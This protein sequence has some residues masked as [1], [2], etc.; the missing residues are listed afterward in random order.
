M[1]TK[2]NQK[3]VALWL[4]EYELHLFVGK[5]DE[6]DQGS[7]LKSVVW[8]A[9][10]LPMT[11]A[12]AQKKLVDALTEV[13][14]HSGQHRTPV[15]LCLGDSMCVTRVSTGDSHRVQREVD[16]IQNRSQLYLSLGLG[17]KLTGQV[18][19]SDPS[20]SEYA[21]TSI[22]SQRVIQQ[23][24]SACRAASVRLASVEPVTLS[25]TRAIGK[26]GLDAKQ[27]VLQIFTDDNRCDLAISCQGRLM[28]SYRVGGWK[29]IED[30]AGLVASHMA[31]LKRFCERYRVVDNAKLEN[32]LLFG[33]DESVQVFHDKLIVHDPD[34]K[35][36]ANAKDVIR[37]SQTTPCDGD[38]SAIV[39]LAM[40]GAFAQQEHDP[41]VIPV[42]DLLQRLEALQPRSPFHRYVSAF[43]PAAAALV[44]IVALWSFSWVQERRLSEMRIFLQDLTEQVREAETQLAG[45]EQK[46]EWLRRMQ[47]VD[48]TIQ[49]NDWRALVSS[50]ARCLPE[51]AKLEN[52]TISSAT[53]LSLKGTMADEDRSYE[54]IS[55]LKTLPLISNVSVESISSMDSRGVDQM[56]FDVRC[57]IK[58]SSSRK[59]HLVRKL[60]K[61]D[62]GENA[63]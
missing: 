7:R 47:A 54:M 18:R 14:R 26:L 44:T 27:P 50:T 5:E 29:N 56:Q 39:Q 3:T 31:R 19:L 60:G 23:I 15:R 25:V 13:M 32:V 41:D 33:S 63:K 49:R 11:S 62:G 21:L 24:Y 57:E 17:D 38:V 1:I 58:N 37:Q 53:K 43:W 55:S 51:N 59:T 9:E 34:F 20:G 42:P 30:A 45:E 35:T 10:R 61:V 40:M 4:D 36:V 22:V 12:D 52:I 2:K 48:R 28:L 46:Q 6:F 16:D 8:N